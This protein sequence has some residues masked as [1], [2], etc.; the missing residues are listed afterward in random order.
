[1]NP[2]QQKLMEEQLQKLPI[3]LQRAIA[4][5][6]W[7][8][9]SKE[10]AGNNNLTPE[11]SESLEMETMFVVY[12][13]EPESSLAENIARELEMEKGRADMIAN[14]ISEKVLS[15]VLSKAEELNIQNGETLQ[16]VTEEKAS[17]AQPAT[18]MTLSSQNANKPS[19]NLIQPPTVQKPMDL[20]PVRI[21]TIVE[22]KLNEVIAVPQTKS[23]YQNG[24]DPY[25]EPLV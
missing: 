25:R 4:Q 11:Q 10:I 8:S 9:L 19:I 24:Q 5:T 16:T 23:V 14:E 15:V 1:M 17:P 7:R 20:A 21:Q 3:P 2:E 12:G 22:K 6:S 13:F 18:Q